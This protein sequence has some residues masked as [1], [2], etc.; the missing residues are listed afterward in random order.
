MLRAI[1]RTLSAVA[2]L[3]IATPA[4]AQRANVSDIT[5]PNVSEAPNPNIP[6]NPNVSDITE[7]NVS[8]IT[9]SNTSDITGTN[10]ADRRASRAAAAGLDND[11]ADQL[12]A[13]LGIAYD[14]CVG[15]GDCSNF[16]TLLETSN[17]ILAE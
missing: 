16:Y 12:A 10:A 7:P 17:N 5:G 13:D 3:T 6:L 11:S 1:A 15:G 8:D 2:V 4:L 14:I 9:G